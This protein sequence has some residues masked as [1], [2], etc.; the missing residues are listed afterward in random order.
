[1][2]PHP[3]PARR[4]ISWHPCAYPCL[5]PSPPAISG[6]CLKNPCL[7]RPGMGIEPERKAGGITGAE[8]PFPEAN[9]SAAFEAVA[10]DFIS[11]TP[12]GAILKILPP[13]SSIL[14]WRAP[15]VRWKESRFTGLA[16]CLTMA[17]VILTLAVMAPRVVL[18]RAP[19]AVAWIGLSNSPIGKGNFRRRFAHVASRRSACA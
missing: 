17:R 16:A 13:S 4:K 6:N 14:F 8:T 1:M 19:A 18:S 11:G 7:S 2:G 12:D 15:P 10:R 3:P 9:S 5:C